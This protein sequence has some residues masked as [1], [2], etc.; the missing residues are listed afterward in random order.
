M[1]DLFVYGTLRRGGSNHGYLAG[2]VCLGH[3]ETEPEYAIVDVG[4]YKGLIAGTETVVGEV[5][6]V[7]PDVL[8][9]VDALEGVDS[10]LYARS[11]V[12]LL[13][14]PAGGVQ[15]YMYCGLGVY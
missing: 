10:G 3:A 15:A 11:P 5:W 7:A 12:R 2:S 6:R 13:N 9:A 4:A 14:W 1:G 8:R